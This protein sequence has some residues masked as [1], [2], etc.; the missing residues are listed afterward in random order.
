MR[1]SDEIINLNQEI[2]IV[3]NAQEGID[4]QLKA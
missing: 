1:T 3:E 2:D 4:E